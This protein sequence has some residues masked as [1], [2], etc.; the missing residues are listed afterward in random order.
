MVS[1][2]TV[3]LDQQLVVRLSKFYTVSYKLRG[4]LAL[5]PPY[6]YTYVSDVYAVPWN[7]HAMEKDYGQMKFGA[8]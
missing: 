5:W 2:A 4:A 6:S 3:Q 1:V 7:I 8:W